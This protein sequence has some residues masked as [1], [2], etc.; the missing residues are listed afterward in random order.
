MRLHVG[1]GD[2]HWPGFTN[3]DAYG[4]PDVLSDC[5]RLPFETC[6]VDEIHSIHFVEHVPRLELENMLFDWNRAL[7]PGGKLVIEVPCLNK[8]AKNVVAG[9][10]NL[11][12]TVLGIFGDPRDKRPGMMHGWCYTQEEL[13]D[14]LE[15][16]G[17]V[18]IEVEEPK[19]HMPER[20][21]RITALRPCLT[22]GGGGSGVLI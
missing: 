19:F 9:E 3:V 5:R 11:R 14:S 16:C 22:M 17:F 15:Q 10:K 8:I 18:N 7:K 13:C 21:M 20:D 1:C 12:L 2:K 6:T 4:D